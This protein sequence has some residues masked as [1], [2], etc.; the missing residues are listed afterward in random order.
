MTDRMR[1]AFFISLIAFSLI[2]ADLFWHR[3]RMGKLAAWVEQQKLKI[4]E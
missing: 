4:T 1:T 3:I 2:F